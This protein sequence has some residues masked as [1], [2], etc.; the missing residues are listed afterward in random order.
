MTPYKGRQFL[1]ARVLGEDGKPAR[2]VVTKIALGMVYYRPV[3]GGAPS[4]CLIEDF[5][6]WA[7]PLP[8]E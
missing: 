3:D 1:H 5:P 6:K 7:K 2:Y 4:C 8:P